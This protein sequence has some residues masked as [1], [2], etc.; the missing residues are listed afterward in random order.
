MEKQDLI[1]EEH[2]ILQF[3]EAEDCFGKRAAQA[4]GRPLFR[5][6]D[7]PITANN[8]MGIHHAWGRSLKDIYIRYKFQRGYACRCQN[9]FDS[10]GLWVEIGVEKELGFGDKR[11][12]EAYGL[13]RFTRD[14]KARVRK[15]AGVITEQSKRL[16]QW[17][18]WGNDYFTNTDENIA[19]IWHF[20]K[21]CHESGWLRQ[22]H[23]PMPWCPRCGTS[24]SEH[25]MTGSYK[26][27]THDSVFFQLPLQAEGEKAR[28]ANALPPDARILVWTTTPWTLSSNVALAVNPEIDYVLVRV[29]SQAAPLVLAKQAIKQLGADKLE[30]LGSL[31][32]SELVGLAYETC[33]PELQAQQGFPH[34][35]VG[36]EDVSA[37][38]GTGVVHIA[39]GCGAEDFALGLR[40]QL[41]QLMPVDDLGVFLEGFGFFSGKDSGAIA[42]EVFGQLQTRGKLYK[43]EPHEH[44]YPVC[45]RCKTPVI[46]RLVPSW[47][48]HV[49]QELRGR[50]ISAAHKV[51]WE[52]ESGGR[53]MEDWLQNMGDWNISRKRYYGLP[54]PFY[55]CPHC[56]ELTV[57]GS[58]EE[59]AALQTPTSPLPPPSSLLP[60]E[61]IVSPL[62]PA[63]SLL[64]PEEA[65]SPLPPPS[66]LLPPELHRPWIDEIEILC[67]H[68]GKPVKRIPDTGDVWM[69]AGIVPYST[70]GYFSDKEQWKQNFPAEWVTEMNEQVRLWF[71]AMLFMSV[72][73]EDRPPY[74][75]VMCHSMV[76]REDGG[77]FSKTG[78][79]IQFNEAAEEIGADAI[80][81]LFAGNPITNDV[82]F[83]FHLGDE[84]RR[85]LLGFRNIHTFFDTYYQLD[86]PCLTGEI[87]PNGPLDTWLLLR[88]NQFIRRATELMNAYKAYVLV[89]EFEEFV[90][91]V[92]NWYIRLNRRRFWKSEDEADQRAA[93]RCLYFALKSAA[94]VMAPIIPF[95][96]EAVWQ[97]L[98]RAAEPDVPVSIHLSEWPRPL[99]GVEDNGLLEQTQLVRE[100]IAA[101]LR[102]RNE[103]NLKVR[104]PLQTLYLVCGEAARVAVRL[105]ERQMLDELNVKELILLPDPE[106]LQTKVPAVNFKLAGAALKSQVNAFKEHLAALSAADA[107]YVAQQ[108]E[109]GGAVCV[110]GWE[111]P[112]DASLFLLQSKT[113][114]G[115]VSTEFRAKAGA[116]AGWNADGAITVALDTTLTE[117]LRQEGAVRDVIRQIQTL[118]REAGY[119]VEQRIKVSIHTESCFL[120]IA[121]EAACERL[122]AE[123]LAEQLLKGPPLPSPD[124]SRTLEIAGGEITLQLGR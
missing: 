32:G 49:T 52:P 75:H 86:K 114:P 21:K 115:I 79:M 122:M 82:R 58:K 71:Y 47:Y 44:S 80:R 68:C 102:L 33:F 91:D 54:L 90:E 67:P 36:W 97:K 105:L 28:E 64:P 48:L 98:V 9:G 51:K 106:A 113:K 56:G 2:E 109:A 5:F 27:M 65:G 94:Q 60:P 74:E 116:E 69:D 121:L 35:I 96:T 59:L 37:E 15:Y 76:A 12:I 89:K 88:A 16:G 104:Q 11:D 34:R 107:S 43:V 117:E 81:Y 46:F 77:K 92:S 26:L 19:G 111:S 103:E 22:E 24:L 78:Y 93:Y 66:S 123:V 124:I 30:V 119:T 95:Q 38:E 72:V 83:G 45:W 3:W 85:K 4:A 62:P 6:L 7:G 42:Q 10:Q 112:L 25:E 87:K 41:P 61:E 14:C 31:K 18:D 29:K 101:A 84:A 53:R 57:V 73:L 55:P 50:L 118:R 99:A 70:L 13:D 110:P 23:K 1:Q 8:P 108:A 120:Q 100:I 40:E 20:L 63:S 39:P 17:M